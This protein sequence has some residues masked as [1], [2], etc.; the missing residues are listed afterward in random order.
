MPL[1]TVIYFPTPVKLNVTAVDVLEV[2]LVNVAV[3]ATSKF[4]PRFMVVNPPLVV[5]P[6]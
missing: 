4:P 5:I 1:A 2:R 6:E 3:L